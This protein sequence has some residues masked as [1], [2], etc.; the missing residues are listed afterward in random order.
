MDVFRWQLNG[1]CHMSPTLSK[2]LQHAR[3]DSNACDLHEIF[4]S[5]LLHLMLGG[6]DAS[7]I[8]RFILGQTVES[9][10][11]T[12]NALWQRCMNPESYIDVPLT[13]ERTDEIS[14]APQVK[15]VHKLERILVPNITAP[16]ARVNS[17]NNDRLGSATY[18]YSTIT[19]YNWNTI[20]LNIRISLRK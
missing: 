11:Y 9:I 8:A 4:V 15:I 12:A 1:V 10:I 3:P 7:L 14:W 5:W 17:M 20:T 6:N 18:V 13:H 16:S 19:E 2:L